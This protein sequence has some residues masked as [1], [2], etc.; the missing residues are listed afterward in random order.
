MRLGPEI[1]WPSRVVPR[2]SFGFNDCAISKHDGQIDHPVLHGAV[3][4][5]ICS[6]II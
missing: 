1:L 5:S 3:A 2:T 4:N 6:T